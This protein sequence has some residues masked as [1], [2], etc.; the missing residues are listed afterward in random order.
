MKEKIDKNTI[1]LIQI[2]KACSLYL[3]KEY[4]CSLTLAGSAESLSEGLVEAINSKPYSTFFV[5]FKRFKAEWRKE[6]TPKTNIILRERNWS[7]NIIKHH[8]K[9]EE[10]M[11]DID[12]QFQSFIV[13]KS[14]L[15]N[16]R[17]LGFQPTPVMR[18]FE[19]VTRDFG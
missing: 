12:L 6:D 3:K 2:N 19:K 1:L 15:E 4:I 11:I 17:K 18:Q 5:M 14:C 16:Y 9:G 13:L 10:T 8:D 7:R